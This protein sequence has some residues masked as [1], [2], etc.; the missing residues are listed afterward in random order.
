M[1]TENTTL[2]IWNGL[3][4]WAKGAIVVGG[5]ITAIVILRK[6]TNL[7]KQVVKEKPQRDEDKGWNK[8][9]DNLNSNPATKA[10][11]S[12]AQM[13]SIANK[14]ETQM[15]GY[16]TRDTQMKTTFKQIKNNADFAGVQAA[17][18]IRTIEA[19]RGIGW[20]AGDFRGNLVSCIQE[21]ADIATQTAINKY[22]QSKNIKYRV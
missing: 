17:F 3:P 18:G 8:E 21:E 9:F 5:A 1:A 6:S 10:T 4:T 12:K 16:G 14:L 11:L 13:A 22:L 2:G 7:L 15:D 19:G 20:L